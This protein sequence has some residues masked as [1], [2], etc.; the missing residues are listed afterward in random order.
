MCPYYILEFKNLM[1]VVVM[2][3]MIWMMIYSV[4]SYFRW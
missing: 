1:V 4:C 2:V 3:M